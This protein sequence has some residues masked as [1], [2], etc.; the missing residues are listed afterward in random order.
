MFKFSNKS[1]PF[2]EGFSRDLRWKMIL[3]VP[4]LVVAAILVVWL[5]V[6]N[7]VAQNATNATISNGRQIAEQ[8]KIIRGYYTRNIVRKAVATG[9]M[10]PSITHQDEPNS[11]PLPATFIHDVSALLQESET[12]VNLYSA[13]PFPNRAERQLDEFQ[14]AAWDFLS[15]NPTETFSRNEVRDGQQIVRVAI[16]DTMTAQGCVNCHNSRPDTPKADWQLGDV[17]GVLEVASVIDAQIA[18]GQ[19]LSNKVIGGAVI[20]GL[21]LIAITFIAT[22]SVTGP[23]NGMTRVMNKIA[24]GDLDGDI[25]ARERKDQIGS[26]AAAMEIFRDQAREKLQLDDQQKTHFEAREAHSVRVTEILESFDQNVRVMLDN[27]DGVSGDM[28]AGAIKLSGTAEHT[29]AQIGNIMS[30]SA[31]ATEN[32]QSVA[33]AAEELSASVE[34]IGNQVTRSTQ[35]SEEA[36]DQTGIANDRVNGLSASALKIGEIVAIIEDIADQ[37]NLLALNATIEAARAGEAG[38]GFAVVANEVKSLAEQTGKATE[39]ISGQITDIQSATEAAVDATTEV[40]R[41]IK[42]INDITVGVAGAVEE[43]SAATREIASSISQTAEAVSSVNS[44]LDE[45]KSG[46]TETNTEAGNVQAGSVRIAEELEALRGQINQFLEDIK[47]A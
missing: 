15:E 26:M 35:A 12:N 27:F 33:S 13:Y 31:I 44:I 7:M 14:Q 47:A 22:G 42:E 46:A 29:D 24:G 28:K 23:L 16:A 5:Y 2:A 37:T 41:T 8:F 17:R 21:L 45:I 6:P 9:S 19:A 40:G 38:K 36:M 30:K 1:I 4:V 10:T 3:P 39:E 43:Q 25:P 20:F 32:N 18:D 11:I 34:E